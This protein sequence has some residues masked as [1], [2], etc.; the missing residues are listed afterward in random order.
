MV[1]QCELLDLSHSGAC[2]CPVDTADDDLALMT[3][4]DKIHFGRHFLGSRRV[5]DV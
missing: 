5:A 1:R 4:I 3:L 2:H